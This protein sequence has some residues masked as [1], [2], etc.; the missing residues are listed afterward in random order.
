[1]RPQSSQQKSGPHRG[2]NRSVVSPSRRC[3][4]GSSSTG[5]STGW[6]FRY[7]RLDRQLVASIRGSH[8]N[9][10]M[11]VLQVELASARIVGD[12]DVPGPRDQ[13]VAV[14][15]G[16]P[17]GRVPAYG[18]DPVSQ[19]A[20][21]TC[22][23]NDVALSRTVH[24]DQPAGRRILH[25]LAAARRNL[26]CRLG[27]TR[28]GPPAG[29]APATRR[30]AASARPRLLF[31]VSKRAPSPR[32]HRS[33]WAGCYPPTCSSPSGGRDF[34]RPSASRF[35]KFRRQYWPTWLSALSSRP[36][37]TCI[38]AISTADCN[39]ASSVV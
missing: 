34:W 27:P 36:C 8:R 38:V 1:M 14:V 22:S 23:R 24:D 30:R 2:T 25:G 13:R 9:V 29:T 31:R 26:L 35:T 20:L 3:A 4:C 28:A 18:V 12:D 5:A 37:T 39:R 32:N 33:T 21:R 6:S 17:F 7:D 11:A 10:K 19:R 16:H 15:Q